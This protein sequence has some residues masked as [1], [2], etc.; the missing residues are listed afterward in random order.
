MSRPASGRVSSGMR[1]QGPGVMRGVKAAS[2]ALPRGSTMRPGHMIMDWLS[3]EPHQV[4]H[5]RRVAVLAA[6]RVRDGVRDRAILLARERSGGPPGTV[7]RV[8]CRRGTLSVMPPAGRSCAGCQLHAAWLVRGSSSGRAD[9]HVT[10]EPSGTGGQNPARPGSGPAHLGRIARGGH[11]PSALSRPIGVAVSMPSPSPV[12]R[13][14]T[15]PGSNARVNARVTGTA[16]EHQRRRPGGRHEH[17]AHSD[18]Q[19]AR[20]RL[21]NEVRRLRESPAGRASPPG[22]TSG[23]KER[24]HMTTIVPAQRTAVGRHRRGLEAILASAPAG[25]AAVVACTVPAATSGPPLHFHAASD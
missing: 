3:R 15:A 23:R 16:G 8:H 1:R 9:I 25:A 10:R 13:R 24:H 2:L 17:D 14:S 18:L 22:R 12:H 11:G 4:G 7:Q 19:R 21:G 5:R 20:Y 6:G